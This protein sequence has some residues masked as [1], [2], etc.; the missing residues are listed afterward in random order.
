M[1]PRLIKLFTRV[2]REKLD[3]IDAGNS[4]LTEDEA[5][6]IMS[7]LCHEPVSRA[8]ACK[9]LNTSRSNFGKLVRAKKI[10]AGRKRKGFT[11]LAWY[12]DELQRSIN[13]K[14]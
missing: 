10:P 6:D 13:K 14:V 11:E 8:G 9:Y 2:A 1:N 5:M 3:C 7:V 12:K 4:E